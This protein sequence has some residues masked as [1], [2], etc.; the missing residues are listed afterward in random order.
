MGRKRE[1]LR[2]CY[3][4][5]PAADA[6]PKARG[7]PSGQRIRRAP[8]GVAG[9]A[10]SGWCRRRSA[11]HAH[12]MKQ[13][14]GATS[15]SPQA[16]RFE[17]IPRL[18]FPTRGGR[19][20]WRLGLGTWSFGLGLWLLGL[21]L[22]C[23][24]ARAQ[25]YVPARDD[26]VL[27]RIPEGLSRAALRRQR[28]ELAEDPGNLRDSVTLARGYLATADS[29]G[30]PRYLGHAQAM[31]TPWWSQ[32][33]PPAEALFLRARIRA[34]QREHAE[35]LRDLELLLERDPARGEA[36]TLRA[37]VRLATADYPAARRDL[38]SAAGKAPP[39]EL[40]ALGAR[41]DSLTGQAGP[42]AERLARALAE[43]PDAPTELRQ[44]AV[45]IL[46]EILG[47]LGR[48]E[49]AR[50]RFEEALAAAPRHVGLLAAWADFELAA[51]RPQAVVE[52][53]TDEA[54]A[55]A[56]LLRL[57]LAQ[58]ALGP[59]DEAEAA[60]LAA[61][62]QALAA[63]LEARRPRGE[64]PTRDDARLALHILG[65][66]AEA[67]RLA[68]AHWQLERGPAEARL[69]AEA[70]LAARDPAAARPAVEWFTAN[71]VEDVGMAALVAKL[72]GR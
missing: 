12:A 68:A 11:G 25:P 14:E 66:P 55:E 29:E 54:A 63:R 57:V 49:E 20:S 35:A 60:A 37:A 51:G 24:P 64:P 13:M 53:L 61:R 62:T 38:A 46:A 70:A 10:R 30:D 33:A 52:R 8:A 17:G 3:V 19:T 42:A 40:A 21:H 26:E 48:A 4:C 27:E 47:R 34:A 67:L 32:P 45:V 5:R 23:L 16:P 9:T 1:G 59:R 18:K 72:E 50:R 65:Q 56:L 58:Q 15:A 2:F 71:Q 69:L 44:A 39:L 36:W 28:A 43:H 41:L 31:L 22:L 7:R 6:G